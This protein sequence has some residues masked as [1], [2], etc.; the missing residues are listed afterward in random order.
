MIRVL[1]AD[2]HELV[3]RG[4]RGLLSTQRC[5]RVVG[6]AENGR[7]A[8]EMAKKLRPNVAIVDIEMPG[9][10]GLEVTREI[11]KFLPDLRVIILSIHESD[12]MVRRVLEVGACGYASKADLARSL[13]KVVRAVSH[14]ENSLTPRISKTVLNG[15]MK[16]DEGTGQQC[17][18]RSPL[19]PREVETVRLLAQGMSNKEAAVALGI[20]VKTTETYRERIMRKL[21]LHSVCELVHYA[22]RCGFVRP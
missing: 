21:N 3:R 16:R 15:F 13:I 8:L 10:D 19:T 20:S 12:E 11:R 6:E 14:G 1:L 5:V 9:M 7:R 22:I 18:S 2:D 4:I 17:E